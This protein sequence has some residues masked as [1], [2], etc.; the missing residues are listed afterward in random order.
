VEGFSD[1]AHLFDQFMDALQEKFFCFRVPMLGTKDFNFLLFCL[2]AGK[3]VDAE[4]GRHETT[5]RERSDAFRSQ[6]LNGKSKNSL[7][8]GGGRSS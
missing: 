7:F 8:L 6:R 2:R 5:G 1:R 3:Y 4:P